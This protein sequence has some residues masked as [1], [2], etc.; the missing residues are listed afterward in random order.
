SPRSEEHADESHHNA[1][2]GI[3]DNGDYGLS[4][5]EEENLLGQRHATPSMAT[6]KITTTPESVDDAPRF[7]HDA[8]VG[9]D[10]ILYALL[11]SDPVA[12]GT[13]TSTNPK[14][15]VGGQPLGKQYCEVIVNVVMKK[16]AILPR[17]Y[18]H[19]DTM[20]GA[21]MMEIAWPYKRLKVSD[22]ASKPS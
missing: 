13:I 9:K 14:T 17:P 21:H 15:I 22:K 11:R 8:L 2:D 18:D 1:H 12:K 20:A 4:E 10:V 3:D 5:E 19:M 6:M 16:D 7:S